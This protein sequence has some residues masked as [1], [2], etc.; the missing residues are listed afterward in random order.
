M[1]QPPLRNI[2]TCASLGAFALV[3]SSCDVTHQDQGPSASASPSPAVSAPAAPS[4]AAVPQQATPA[5]TPSAPTPRPTYPVADLTLTVPAGR[6]QTF[7]GM[8][9]SLGN[10]RGEYQTLAPSDRAKLSQLMWRD[11]GFKILKVWFDIDD[12]STKPGEKNLATMR[13]QY[14]DSGIIADA[15]ANGMTTLLCA[16]D[17]FPPYMVKPGGGNWKA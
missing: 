6:R 15:R 3:L 7:A 14:V 2:F 13:K 9:T 12:Y 5:A 11:T 10:F 16:F 17:H 4:T 8:G 1:A